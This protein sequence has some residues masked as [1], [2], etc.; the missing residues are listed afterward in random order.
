MSDTH[1]TIQ[2]IFQDTE[3]LEELK[4]LV[5]E[6]L[7]VMP[8]TL[9]IA[10]GSEELSKQELI[11]HVAQEDNVGKQIMEMELEFIQD[12]ASGAIYRNE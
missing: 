1:N 3:M 5:L 4:Q 8:D 10:I 12:L 2:D 11:K 6:R 9:N 7:K